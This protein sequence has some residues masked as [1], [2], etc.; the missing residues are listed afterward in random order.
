MIRITE[1]KCVCFS[2]LFLLLAQVNPVGG[3][4]MEDSVDFVEP[5]SLQEAT[6]AAAVSVETASTHTEPKSWR[7]EPA[8]M[9]THPWEQGVEPFR[10]A[11]NLY[12][13][14]N[15][16]VSSHLI[17]TSSGLVL[18]DTGFPQTVYLLLES[19]RKLGFDP[20]D[21][22]LILHTHAHYD[23]FGGTRALVELTGAKTAMGRED[24]ELLHNRAELTWA[25]Q[26]AV[27]LYE[28]FEV[29]IPLEDGQRLKSGSTAIECYHIPGHTPGSFCYLFDVTENGETY[30]VGLYGGPGRNSLGDEYL[31]YYKLPMSNRTDYLNS[32]KRM[33]EHKVDIV[34][35][36][37]PSQND[38]F[39]KHKRQTPA[40]NPFID[41]NAWSAYMNRLIENGKKEWGM[42]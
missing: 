32:A 23:H 20:A 11:G 15:R 39:G 29:D 30:R 7:D 9:C 16:N 40:E 3:E 22:Q 26:Y 8:R 17:K 31:K 25:R 19:I 41:S 14:G 38:T 34:L 28:T 6:P 24:I 4:L 1:L 18:I 12:Y 21:L 27:E 33:L 2:S 35:G 42:E 5:A 13:V 37:H 10:I 36:A